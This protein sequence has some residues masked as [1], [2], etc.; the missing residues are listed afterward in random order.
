MAA[1]RAAG[2][3]KAQ[4]HPR[5]KQPWP[6]VADASRR[7]AIAQRAKQRVPKLAAA[8]C[9]EAA[10]GRRGPPLKRAAS[11]GG[12]SE[13]TTSP[14]P[15]KRQRGAAP[16]SSEAAS[17][18]ALAVKVA[19]SDIS[20]P[21]AKRRAAECPRSSAAEVEEIAHGSGSG[22]HYDVLRITRTATVAEVRSAYRKGA[23]ATHPD[24]G[25]DPKDF[26]RLVAAFA[27]LS[28][29]RKRT[30]Y[31]RHLQ[32]SGLQDGLRRLRPRRRKADEH[33]DEALTALG[34]R[35]RLLQQQIIEKMGASL[36]WC[37]DLEAVETELLAALCRQLSDRLKPLGSCRRRVAPSA[38]RSDRTRICTQQ[39]CVYALHSTSG[40]VS[41]FVQLSWAKF[42]VRTGTTPCL[43]EAIDWHIALAEIA[44]LHSGRSATSESLDPIT[45][46]EERRLLESVPGITPFYRALGINPN[47]TGTGEKHRFINAP[48]TRCCRLAVRQYHDLLALARRGVSA[49]SLAVER[50]RLRLEAAAREKALL[51]MEWSLL[52]AI[53]SRLKDRGFDVQ[54][55][56]RRSPSLSLSQTSASSAQE[57][58]E[59]LQKS[60]ALVPSR[61]P[62]RSSIQPSLKAHPQDESPAS[63]LQ[64]LL[65]L[66]TDE[67][68]EVVEALRAL[69][70]GEVQRRARHL[71][72]GLL[73]S[74]SRS[75]VASPARARRASALALVAPSEP[76]AAEALLLPAPD[77]AL[78]DISC[79]DASRNLLAWLG[80]ADLCPLRSASKSAAAH[81]KYETWTRLKDFIYVPGQFD[82]TSHR[83][84]RGRMLPITAEDVCRRLVRFLGQP[85]HASF[86][87]RMDLRQ[88][89]IGALQ[90]VSL[91]SVLKNGM[92]RLK[93]V[94][95]PQE[96]WGGP[97][98]RRRF[99]NSL[100]S[101]V[102]VDFSLPM[103]DGV[104]PSQQKKRRM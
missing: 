102:S 104:T 28:D 17:S 15:Q 33:G 53:Q 27:I 79:V 8:S 35:A 21:K 29:P 16:G 93:Q 18:S 70:R 100:S 36:E 59:R 96:G 95:A 13:P 5:P 98:E 80:W 92:P 84:I 61:R 87:E 46:E 30:E 23:L 103:R 22:G 67:T 91:L 39:K 6:G 55:L 63:A 41:Y 1:K 78:A 101:H 99:V 3:G 58:V 31:D 81:V 50:Q 26:R 19:P 52:Q 65:G 68:A 57:R 88:A 66:S 77:C 24:K 40:T 10:P 44:S 69:P 86:V 7:N 82:P 51:T 9:A 48:L 64:A 83:S 4:V 89:P 49:A 20:P 74:R 2:R 90:S 85:M 43:A 97:A 60:T 14:R 72:A 71:L 11:S 75:S 94:T 37:E 54:A 32:E 12:D 47:T 42:M 45:A 73:P 56:R 25:G 76:S 62:G 38:A 34:G